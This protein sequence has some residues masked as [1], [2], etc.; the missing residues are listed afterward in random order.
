MIYSKA[1]DTRTER[2]NRWSE[3]DY[4]IELNESVLKLLVAE[5]EWVISKGED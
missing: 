2:A 4:A 1:T 3:A 5:A